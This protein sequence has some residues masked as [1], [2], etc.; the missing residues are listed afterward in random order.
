MLARVGDRG[1]TSKRLARCHLVLSPY[2]SPRRPVEPHWP[3]TKTPQT[4]KNH[5]NHQSGHPPDRKP[6]RRRARGDDLIDPGSQQPGEG[7]RLHRH[8][9]DETWV[10]QE[11]NLTFQLGDERHQAG[12]GDIV[13]ALLACC[14]SSPMTVPGP[15]TSFVFT[16]TRR[17]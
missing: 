2:E 5:A 4:E 15:Q 1:W 3:R 10:V 7:P 9:Y 17:W 6:Q 13:I 12:P 11:G 16:P 8:P 14:T